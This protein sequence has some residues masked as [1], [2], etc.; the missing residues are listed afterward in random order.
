MAP[1]SAV[2]LFVGQPERKSHSVCYVVGR[3]YY[4]M[5][6]GRQPQLLHSSPSLQQPPSGPHGGSIDRCVEPA[7][8]A[9]CAVCSLP[10]CARSALVSLRLN[11]VCASPMIRCIYTLYLRPCLGAADISTTVSEGLHTHSNHEQILGQGTCWASCLAGAAASAP[12]FC[13]LNGLLFKGG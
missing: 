1:P 11:H 7:S 8:S 13:A 5:G 6:G 2:C 12:S 4:W 3:G 9:G 10:C